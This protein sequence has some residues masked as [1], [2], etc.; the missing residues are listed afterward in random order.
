MLPGRPVPTTGAMK[1]GGSPHAPSLSFLPAE[2]EEQQQQL[3]R[4]VLGSW[5]TVQCAR[6]YVTTS[7]GCRIGPLAVWVR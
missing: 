2:G 1:C 5:L 4:G 7:N 6:L 3:L